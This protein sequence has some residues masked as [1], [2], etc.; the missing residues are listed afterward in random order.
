MSLKVFIADDEEPARER[1]KT[2]LGDIAQQVPTTVVGEARH[3]VE[4]VE[5]VP[6]SG[7]EVVL[8]DIQMPGMNGL[9]VARHL[10]RL[11]PPPRIVFVTAHDRHAVEAFELNALDY[12]LKP[13][14][15]ERL[16]AALRKAA[17]PQQEQLEKAAEGPREY[18]SVAERNRIVLV[19]VRD[20]LFLRAEQK[21]VTVRTQAREH[22]VEEPLIALEREFAASFVRIHRNCLVARAAIRGF[23]R[24][25]GEE[26]E[27]HWQVVLDGLEERLPV[28]RRQWPL[29]RD[30]VA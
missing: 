22:L 28:S 19:P 4:A 26:E 7:A 12:L 30:L 20:I 9:E 24:A 23:E 10:A 25:P 1:L 21:Y 15:A 18:L 16:T 27:P 17:V 6:P 29:L 5:Q 14:R 3:G 2:L 8:L 11:E 13:V